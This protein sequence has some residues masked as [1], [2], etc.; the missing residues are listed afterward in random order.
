MADLRNAGVVP[1]T[2]IQAGSGAAGTSAIRL[3]LDNGTGCDL[4]RTAAV[5]LFV[6]KV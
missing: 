4:D 3:D 5:H 1:G 2:E 6:S